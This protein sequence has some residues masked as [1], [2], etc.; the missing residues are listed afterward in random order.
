MN[1]SPPRASTNS[2]FA[3]IQGM[4]GHRKRQPRDDDIRKRITGHV[5]PHSNTIGSEENTASRDLKSEG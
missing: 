1:A 4:I 3:S 2:S 5:H